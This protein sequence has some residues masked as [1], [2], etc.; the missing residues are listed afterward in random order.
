MSVA[1]RLITIF[2]IAAATILTRFLPFIIFK[3]NRPQFVEYLAKF[4]PATM[5]GMLVVYC[6][7]DI[8]FFSGSHGI[9]EVAAVIAVIALHLYK[10][11]VLLS[12]L[13]GTVCY[14][15]LVQVIF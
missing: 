14:M 5:F 3:N 2:I 1:E 15:V 11:N 9:P 6:L 4:L 10:R 12:V 7:K 8:S 13:G